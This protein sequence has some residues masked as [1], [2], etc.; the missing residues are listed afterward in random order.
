MTLLRTLTSGFLGALTLTLLHESARRFIPEAPR[1]DLLGMRSL[2]R[3]LRQVEVEPPSGETLH[4]AALVG[5]LVAN[6]L[7]YSLAGLGRPTSAPW[8]G[9]VL[10]MVA[11][12]G[13]VLLPGSLGLGT[14]PST[15]T[16]ATAAMSVSWYL[17]GGV[18]AGL[19]VRT[20][21]DL[22]RRS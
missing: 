4:R 22:T 8:R 16:P 19:A 13:S 6:T 14:V 15:R 5:D 20:L 18:T 1:L 12:I 11:G 9:A 10:G 21:R 3:G 17:I 7:Y 2:A